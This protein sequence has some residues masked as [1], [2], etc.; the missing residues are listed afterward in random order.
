[1]FW[2]LCLH[3]NYSAKKFLHEWTIKI[4]PLSDMD[5]RFF[6][7]SVSSSGESLNTGMPAGVT[8]LNEIILFLHD[9]RNHFKNLENSNRAMHEFWHARLLIK[10]NF[11]TSSKDFV[12]LVHNVTQSFFIKFH[13]WD[14]IFWKAFIMPV[15]DLRRST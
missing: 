1:M 8:G 11:D 15:F 14:R 7:H 5:L 6:E 9:D 4:H 10:Q 3:T 13:Y 2:N 12:N